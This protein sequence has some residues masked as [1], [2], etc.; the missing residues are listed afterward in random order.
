MELNFPTKRH[1]DLDICAKCGSVHFVEKL[2]S[3]TVDFRGLTLDVEGLRFNSC[4]TCGHRTASNEQAVA[5]EQTIRRAYAEERDM[6]RTRDGLL[7]SD[8]I[9]AIR[10]KFTLTQRDAAILFGGGPNAFNK[11]ESGEVLQSVA[12][13]RL[14]RLSE[15]GGVPAVSYLAKIAQRLRPNFLASLSS[16][17]QP[18]LDLKSLHL[19]VQDSNQ[20]S[21]LRINNEN[22]AKKILESI[23]KSYFEP[24]NIPALDQRSPVPFTIGPTSSIPKLYSEVK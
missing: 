12:M 6:L 21:A 1:Q 11:Y 9:S 24:I 3:D 10:K 2:I 17:D 16:I 15:A 22:T 5:N 13:D 23:D 14:L 8:E 18:L 19:V 7:S 4:S 20:V